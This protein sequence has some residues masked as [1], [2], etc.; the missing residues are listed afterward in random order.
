[1]NTY[2]YAK[3]IVSTA[4]ASGKYVKELKTGPILTQDAVITDKLIMN[5]S[6]QMLYDTFRDIATSAGVPAPLFI[7]DLRIKYPHG[8]IST[9]IAINDCVIEYR[10]SAC[11]EKI[12]GTGID[13]FAFTYLKTFVSIGIFTLVYKWLLYASSVS[14]SQLISPKDIGENDGLT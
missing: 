3:P 5:K 10:A 11:M 1:M 2:N 13:Q 7:V 14:S 4:S 12:K 9:T 6:M 8:G